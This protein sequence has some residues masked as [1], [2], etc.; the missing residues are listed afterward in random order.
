MNRPENL[1]TYEQWQDWFIEKIERDSGPKIFFEDEKK[2]IQEDYD[3]LCR[4]FKKL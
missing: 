1:E 4:V 2:E 3:T